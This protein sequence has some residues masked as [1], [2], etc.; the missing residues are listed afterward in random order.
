[1]KKYSSSDDDSLSSDS[2]SDSGEELAKNDDWW[3]D[4]CQ[5]ATKAMRRAL[6]RLRRNKHSGSLRRK[7][8]KLKVHRKQVLRSAF[9][10]WYGLNDIFRFALSHKCL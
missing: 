7:Y 1:M 9:E 4:E 8:K 2:D 3:T 5:E 6:N 10:K